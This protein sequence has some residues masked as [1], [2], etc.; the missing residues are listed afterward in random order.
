MS[1]PPERTSDTLCLGA[2]ASRGPDFYHTCY[3]L[4]GLS[5]TQHY[6]YCVAPPTSAPSSVDSFS[7]APSSVGSAELEFLES[8]G[9]PLTT[10]F[11]WR[12]TPR[13]PSVVKGIVEPVVEDLPMWPDDVA[14]GGAGAVGDRLCPQHPLFNVPFECVATVEAWVRGKVGF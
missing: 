3:V 6:F 14:E 5:N 10:A 11:L 2:N 7:T 1:S 8:E 13:I 12:V 4:L 9:L